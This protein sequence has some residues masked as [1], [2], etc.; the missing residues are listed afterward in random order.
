[1]ANVLDSPNYREIIVLL[2]YIECCNDLPSRSV[3]EH[4]FFE[5]FAPLFRATFL[6]LH[7]PDDTMQ[8]T[9][10]RSL[11]KTSLGN[12]PLNVAKLQGSAG[13]NFDPRPLPIVRRSAGRNLNPSL[14]P[15]CNRSSTTAPTRRS[16][17]R[18]HP[19]FAMA[20]QVCCHIPN[21]DLQPRDFPSPQHKGTSSSGPQ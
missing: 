3:F 5:L 10:I 21:V 4:I 16:K 17:A 8:S 19:R 1:M 7:H 15:P 20:C 11:I 18:Q 2:F 13:K 9:K 14:T 6:Q 12:K